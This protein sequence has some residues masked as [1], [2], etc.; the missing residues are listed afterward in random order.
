MHSAAALRTLIKVQVAFLAVAI[1]SPVSAAISEPEIKAVLLFHLTQYVTWPAEETRAPFKIGVLGDDPIAEHLTAATRGETVG[2]R[3]IL[4]MKS[5]RLTD[6]LDC[7]I[8]YV[9]P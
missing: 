2:G 4:V 7:E 3:E 6:L 8:I 9:S 5:T 1:A